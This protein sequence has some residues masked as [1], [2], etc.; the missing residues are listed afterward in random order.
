MM[1]ILSPAILMN[2]IPENIQ[3]KI[4]F[5]ES[6]YFMIAV[7]CVNNMTNSALCKHF[8][9]NSWHLENDDII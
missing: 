2:D 5:I 9:I 7:L 6:D 3:V 1:P 8:A 4:Y